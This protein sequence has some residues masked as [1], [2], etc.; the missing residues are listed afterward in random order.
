M[1]EPS[2]LLR[3]AGGILSYTLRG[4]VAKALLALRARRQ[5]LDEAIQSLENY[6]R[7]YQNRM[8]H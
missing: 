4:S 3:V 2:L 8:A 6:F 1:W 5:L 7:T